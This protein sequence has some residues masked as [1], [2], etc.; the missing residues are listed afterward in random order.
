MN[1]SHMTTLYSDCLQSE[2]AERDLSIQALGVKISKKSEAMS[3]LSE[4]LDLFRAKDNENVQIITELKAIKSPDQSNSD[5][6]SIGK[7]V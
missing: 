7:A 2:M 5:A 1:A 3:E 6:D 4:E